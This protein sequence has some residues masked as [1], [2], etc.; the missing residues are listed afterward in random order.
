MSRRS[1]GKGEWCAIDHLDWREA[2]VLPR[3]GVQV[4]WFGQSRPLQPA[5]NWSL[6]L[7]CRRSTRPFPSG[8]YAVVGMCSAPK[9]L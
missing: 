8:W 9:V 3:R 4:R 1:A 6:R 7:W 5:R 2:I